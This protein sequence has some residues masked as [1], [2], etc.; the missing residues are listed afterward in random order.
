LNRDQKE[1]VMHEKGP[2]LILAGAGSG[3]TRVLVSKVINLI[4]NKKIKSGSIMMITFTNK[5]ATEMKERIGN[6]Y[7][8]GYIGTF[9]SFCAK[10]LRIEGVNINLKKNFVI[11]D[12]DD[13][14]TMI[15]DILKNLTLTKKY[16]AYYFL[17]R[18]SA[19]KNQLISPERYSSIFSDY[20][21]ADTTSVY[22][23]YQEELEKSNAVDF[24]DLLVLAIKLFSS[25]KEILSKYQDRYRYILVDEF[26]DTNLAQYLLTKMLGQKYRNITVVGDFSQSIYS[27]R[28]AEIKNLEKLKKDFPEAKTFHLE[29]NYRSSAP[30]L[31]FAY[32]VISRNQTHPILDL[33]TDRRGGDEVEFY[34]AINQEDEAIYIAQKTADLRSVYPLEEIAVLYRTNAQ[35]RAIEEVF[36]HNGLSYLLIGGTRFYERKEIK[37]I[38]SYLRLMVN[39]V[40]RVS[41]ER[42]RKLGKRRWERFKNYYEKNK[43]AIEIKET[44]K[45]IDEIGVATGYLEIYNPDVEEDFAR[46]ENIKELKSVAVAFPNLS[47][48]LEQVALV[49]SEYFEGEKKDG[50]KTGVRLMTLHQAKGLEFGAVFVVGLEEGLL[51]HS[52]SMEDPYSLEEERRLFYVGI[53]RAKDKLYITYAR[54]RVIF[55]SRNYAMKS[56]FLEE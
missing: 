42:I 43:D 28:G 32:K 39:P 24:D 13:Q 45:I 26:Q 41:N 34:E 3:K 12:D 52:R 19:A 40:D 30:I 54:Q 38:L 37:D 6:K 9:H 2:S 31:N 16:S 1:A 49:E 7:H 14:S 50:K 33:Y 18:I 35:S 53:T 25:K 47:R 48:F 23:K 36:L 11:Y 15:K 5:A 17:N 21:A 4:E 44:I 51:P 56:R 8:L 46:L 29:K 27:W 20:A 55:G 22:K 10:I